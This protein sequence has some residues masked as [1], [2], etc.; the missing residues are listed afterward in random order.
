M[1]ENIAE[2][3]IVTI[4]RI[5]AKT[6]TL[7]S[8]DFHGN[9]FRCFLSFCNWPISFCRNAF[10]SSLINGCEAGLLA[11]SNHLKL[12]YVTLFIWIQTEW[13]DMDTQHI[14]PNT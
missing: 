4:V 12:K 10:S 2:M 1:I 5:S 3:R 9:F 8:I 13:M 11:H 14:A 6:G 7:V